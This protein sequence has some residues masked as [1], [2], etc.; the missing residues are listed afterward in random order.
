MMTAYV[1]DGKDVDNK[2][3]RILRDSLKYLEE[4]PKFKKYV[5]THRF[6]EHKPPTV[7]FSKKK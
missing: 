5:K 7:T 1:P 2:H 3:I 4:I 6:K